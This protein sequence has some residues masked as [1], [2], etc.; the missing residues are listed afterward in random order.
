MSRNIIFAPS[1]VL[2]SVVWVRVHAQSEPTGTADRKNV[3]K[4]GPLKS[5]WVHQY[6]N[7]NAVTHSS[8]HKKQCCVTSSAVGLAAW[9]MA[10]GSSLAD[11]MERKLRGSRPSLH[12]S[13]QSKSMYEHPVTLLTATLNME[14]ARTSK[15][16][17][18]CHTWTLTHSLCS[19]RPWRWRQHVFLST[20]STV[21][22]TWTLAHSLYSLRP[23]RW[24][25]HMKHCHTLTLT[26]SLYSLRPWRWRQHVFLS[27][28]ST[29]IFFN[30]FLIIF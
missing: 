13:F 18:H 9:K 28:C 19:L 6:A 17:Q 11:Q 12:A 15:P 4:Y 21:V 10:A 1:S 22:H 29:V 16:M 7:I 24:R 30:C 26:H 5:H 14:A 3:T 27:P 2:I 23:W 8:A 20:C 25:K